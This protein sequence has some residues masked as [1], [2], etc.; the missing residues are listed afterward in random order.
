M[1]ITV[2]ATSSNE[3]DVEWLI[4]GQLSST[5]RETQ[6]SSDDG[7][8]LGGVVN[9]DCALYVDDAVEGFGMAN[10]EFDGDI[11]TNEV[12]TERDPPIY[13]EGQ[14]NVSDGVQWDGGVRLNSNVTRTWEVLE[15]CLMMSYGLKKYRKE[16]GFML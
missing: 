7:I 15:M 4:Y 11:L 9:Q 16:A 2:G 12:E 6:F 8:D 5:S 14:W 10:K 1:Q 13:D 3:E